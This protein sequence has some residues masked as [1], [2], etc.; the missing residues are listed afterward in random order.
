MRLYKYIKQI[1]VKKNSLNFY[2]KCYYI[3]L[4][5]KFKYYI[6]KEKEAPHEH[7]CSANGL[8]IIRNPDLI[9]SSS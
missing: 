2:F 1:F 3:V 5:H 7:P 8:L 4:L 9:N 6:F